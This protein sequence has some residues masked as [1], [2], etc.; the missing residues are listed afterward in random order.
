MGLN[1]TLVTLTA[2]TIAHA[3]DVNTSLT[4]LNAATSILDS[5]NDAHQI[6]GH[7]L[8][9]SSDSGIYNF[10]DSVSIGSATFVGIKINNYYDG[11]N[12]RFMVNSTTAYQLYGN[13]SGFYGK[14][15]TNTA[16]AG[17]TI[18]WSSSTTIY[19]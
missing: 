19:S 13:G 7:D 15:S 5:G 11:A 10:S 4:N 16:T 9:S 2:N 8:L 12:D 6:I 14:K 3:A 1:A 18:T 17:S